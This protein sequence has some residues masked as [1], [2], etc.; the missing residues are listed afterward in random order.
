[1]WPS[2]AEAASANPTH[3]KAWLWFIVGGA[4]IL[5]PGVALA[6]WLDIP[7]LTF[8]SS[9]DPSTWVPWVPFLIVVL[10]PSIIFLSVGLWAVAFGIARR[11]PSRH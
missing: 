8:V 2:P 7:F 11:S 3:G 6:Y 9:S 1:M 10:A 5:V 4:F